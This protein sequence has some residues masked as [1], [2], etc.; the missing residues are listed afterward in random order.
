MLIEKNVALKLLHFRCYWH[1]GCY[2][3]SICHNIINIDR[4]KN[5]P[6]QITN[7]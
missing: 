5:Y 6:S 2:C 4:V 1:G 3:I 7:P